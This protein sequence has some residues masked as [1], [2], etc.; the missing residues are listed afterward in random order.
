ATNR[1][2]TNPPPAAPNQTN[3]PPGPVNSSKPAANPSGLSLEIRCTN[4]VLKVGDEIP[5]EF[6]ISNHGTEEY[7][8]ADTTIYSTR[9]DG[10]F[11]LI[12]KT[13]S[14][15]TVPG[16]RDH[17]SEGVSVGVAISGVLHS[18]QSAPPEA[19]D[20]RRIE[21]GVVLPSVESAPPERGTLWFIGADNVVLHPGESFSKIIPLNRWALIREPG[22]YVVAGNYQ[23]TYTT[24]PM[25]PISADPITITVL[26]RTKEEMAGYI[27]GLTNQVA[28][29]LAAKAGRPA[30][31]PDFLD[32]VLV[33]LL[34]KLMDTCNPEIVP[35]LL[36]IASQAGGEGEW[37][38]EALLHYMPQTEEIWQAIL[39]TAVKHRL[40][41]NLEYLLLDYDSRNKEMKP[42]IARSLALQNPDEWQ[43]GAAL[44]AHY[45][46]DAFTARLLAIAVDPNASLETRVAAIEALAANHT[47]PGA[48]TFKA[49]LTNPSPE[50]SEALIAAIEISYNNSYSGLTSPTGK[51]LQLD[52]KDL[53]PLIERLLA[54][55]KPA[56]IIKGV[57]LADASGDEEVTAKLVALA[58][59][60]RSIDREGAIHA[61]SL[62]R[63][64]E[65]VKA[66]KTLL[67]DPDPDLWAP[68]ADAIGQ[69][70]DSWPEARR[71]LRTEDFGAKD[72]R[73]LMERL[74]ASNRESDLLR[75]VRLAA[76]SGGDASTPKLVE[77]A[78]DPGFPFRDAAIH[79]LAFNRTD[80]AVR[81]LKTLLI[82]HDPQISKC[83]EEAI[84]AAYTARGDALGRPLRADDFDAKL[85]QP[86]ARPATNPA[87]TNKDDAIPSSESNRAEDG[88]KKLAPS[89]TV[90][91]QVVKLIQLAHSDPT[92][93]VAEVSKAWTNTVT[94][95]PDFRTHQV[96]VRATERE[97]PG[98]EEL[99]RQ[100]DSATNRF[101]TNPPPAAPNQTNAPPG[102]VNSSKPAA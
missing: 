38:N 13:A 82:D 55:K 59:N 89:N 7:M 90:E 93:I 91:P 79:A 45:R 11:K 1:F 77:L 4:E 83:A 60:P 100:L 68:L 53:T 81:E 97:M 102:P 6:I 64:D 65:G 78:A 94:I 62:N 40:N 39:Q 61:L 36:T 3:A 73:P 2:P 70:Y 84:R 96:I 98:V 15:A 49:L 43:A 30:G 20:L 42:V 101:P 8:Y 28:A 92:N 35:T 72:M 19:F 34:S 86:K 33:G 85:Q 71:H 74:L 46:D 87:S 10:Q 56:D 14:G 80:E 57:S 51:R 66:L 17:I 63:T 69:G 37:A 18:L 76:R 88:L 23:P 26:P 22:R 58:T 21:V 12:A 31:A 75:G 50:I 44:A 27:Q 52:A 5:I 99:I 54:S 29:Q 24:N 32:P 67:N 47:D 16:A 25:A 95:I 41:P 9:L 48:K